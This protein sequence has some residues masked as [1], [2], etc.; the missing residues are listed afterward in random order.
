MK[1][2]RQLHD[3]GGV[4]IAPNVG[5]MLRKEI[6]GLHSAGFPSENL[7]RGMDLD[8]L[9]GMTFEDLSTAR[10]DA[11]LQTETDFSRD[12]DALAVKTNMLLGRFG[13]TT[14]GTT[15]E[16]EA[17]YR[18]ARSTIAHDRD[19]VCEFFADF[20]C[21]GNHAPSAAPLLAAI[22]RSDAFGPSIDGCRSSFST[23][24]S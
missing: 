7:I 19:F 23:A 2:L 22:A 1:K 14:E 8:G 4:R 21:R 18:S 5:E 13:G 3:E 24:L 20:V 16:R 15:E 6:Q 10:R 9:F 17:A 11:L 12:I